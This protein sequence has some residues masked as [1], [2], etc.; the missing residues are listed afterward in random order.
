MREPTNSFF[1]LVPRSLEQLPTSNSYPLWDFLLF[2]LRFYLRALRCAMLHIFPPPPPPSPPHLLQSN[3]THLF[4]LQSHQPM[5]IR[6]PHAL[7]PWTML[8]APVR[9]NTT[10]TTT[11]TRQTRHYSIRLTCYVFFTLVL[12]FCPSPSYLSFPLLH[13][14]VLPSRSPVCVCVQ[15]DDL[16][17]VG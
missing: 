4:L 8:C 12:G 3:P 5:T 11:A 17:G 16:G 6:P 10:N 1:N 14:P 7:P 15:M 2:L 13:Y 9:R